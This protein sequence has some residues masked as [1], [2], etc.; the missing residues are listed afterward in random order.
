MDESSEKGDAAGKT[1]PFKPMQART[2]RAVFHW[3]HSE[4]A[5]AF[6]QTIEAVASGRHGSH[7]AVKSPFLHP[8]MNWTLWTTGR[9][10]EHHRCTYAYANVQLPFR[11]CAPALMAIWQRTCAAADLRMGKPRNSFCLTCWNDPAASDLVVIV[12]FCLIVL[13]AWQQQVSLLKCRMGTWR[14]SE[15][16]GGQ[17]QGI[18][19]WPTPLEWLN[20]TRLAQCLSSKP[21]FQHWKQGFELPPH[22]LSFPVC[23]TAP[24]PWRIAATDCHVYSSTWCH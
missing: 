24:I 15:K 11:D 22:W 2:M 8:L 10:P 23:P 12:H 17:S 6:S 5:L 20:G 13:A 7:A 14:T 4:P 3:K 9:I 16:E 18:S 19:S 21:S 1:P